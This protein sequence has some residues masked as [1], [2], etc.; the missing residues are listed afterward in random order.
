MLK[1]ALL[2]A[3]LPAALEAAPLAHFAVL[4]PK[5]SRPNQ[6]RPRPKPRPAPRPAPRN[7]GARADSLNGISGHVFGE[8]RSNFPELEEKGSMDMGGYMYY[9]VKPG[10]GTGWFAKNAENVSTIYRFYKDQFASFDA[11]A[12][13]ASRT[14]LAEEAV[15]LFGKGQPPAPGSLSFGLGGLYWEGKRVQVKLEDVGQNERRLVIISKRVVAQKA[16]DEAAQKK[17][18]AAARAAKLKADNAPTAH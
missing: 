7:Y 15:Y 2:F 10:Q 13:G 9:N 12:Y 6:T 3:L 1:T 18:E 17:S 16:A 11:S 4:L 5:E 8:S 14:L